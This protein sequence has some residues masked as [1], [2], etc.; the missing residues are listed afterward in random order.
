MKKF[1]C[2]IA[3]LSAVLTLSSCAAEKAQIPGKEESPAA[4]TE[5]APAETQSEIPEL[6]DEADDTKEHE[7]KLPVFRDP[8][9]ENNVMIYD[10]CVTDFGTEPSDTPDCADSTDAF[11]K[12]LDAAKKAGGGTVYVPAGYYRVDGKLIVPRSVCLAGEWYDPDTAP[13]KIADGTVIVTS[14]G[15]DNENS[16]FV[17]VG[18]SASVMGLTF[19]YPDQT[20][21]A[22][23]PC[24]ATVLLKDSIA[25]DGTQ[26][27]A[28]A[29]CLTFVNSYTAIDASRGNQLHYISSARITAFKMGFA[30]NECYDCGRVMSMSIR[31]D[32][33]GAFITALQG[34]SEGKNARDLAAE[35]MRTGATGVLL[36]R[37]D[38]QMMYDISISSCKTA[39]SLLRNPN[40]TG[41]T[42]GNGSII[43]F[44]IENC[45]TGIVCA[46]GSYKFSLGEI[47]TVGQSVTLCDTAVAS[48]DFYDCTLS[49]QHAETV[50]A[51][52]KSRG[53]LSFQNC[54]FSGW[55]GNAVSV[56][57]GSFESG[58]CTYTGEGI[59]IHINPTALTAVVDGSVWGENIT[60]PV[61][62]L[63]DGEKRTY[64]SDSAP[65]EKTEFILDFGKAPVPVTDNIVYVTDFGA[66]GKAVCG[67]DNNPD[68]TPAFEAAINALGGGGIVYVPA[69][70]YNVEGTLTVPAG[71]EIRGI[72]SGYHVTTGEGSVIFVTNGKGEADG[73]PFITLEKGSGVR[74]LTFWYPEQ[75][76]K[77]IEKYPFLIR[78]NGQDTWVR[79]IC[80]G[81]C[82]QAIDMGSADCGGHYI[83]NIT[84]CVLKKAIV[85]DGSTKASYL[86]NTHFN[87]SFYTAVWGTKLTDASGSFGQNDMF[88]TLLGALNGSLDAYTFGKTTDENVLFIFNYRA[89]TG[90]TFTGGFDGTV[91]GC[92]VDGSVA[93][94][95]ITGTYEKPLRLLNFADDIVPGTNEVGNT[96]IYSAPDEGSEVHFVASGASSYNY[97]PPYLVRAVSGKLV[98]RGFS[99]NVSPVGRSAAILVEGADVEA[100]GI[101]F[102]H[103]GPLDA[104]GAFTK[105]LERHRA[106]D[107]R[108]KS[109]RL[110]LNG[111]TASGFFSCDIDDSGECTALGYT[112]TEQ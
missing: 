55:A 22:I 12:A 25:G 8:R 87:L 48:F 83:E 94:V 49:S 67:V 105:Q 54:T 106:Y 100:S 52:E 3:F 20:P 5:S 59:G 75:N 102:R 92:G 29:S 84:G 101:T 69:G 78:G 108:V 9:D 93:G 45:E 51:Q 15:F 4:I 33:Y 30:V 41:E 111:A 60:S 2:L 32:Y 81:N 73:T 21:D 24:G 99:A 64:I 17:T 61:V 10:F 37:S 77:R 28:N 112:V 47:S 46:Y 35:A 104:K 34:E 109:G 36:M 57:G 18:A 89:A 43:D 23:K 63:L 44:T 70:Y 26:H 80:V 40:S 98:L 13:G 76:Y 42:A 74:G 71:V 62:N 1:L 79:D 50:L 19:Y 86:L 53:H 14:Y 11:K 58:S 68:D 88:S 31:P 6:T 97:V 107:V 72:H 39:F 38:W 66:D 110:R 16:A 85:V 95:K 103:V 7:M 65:L 56:L 82:Y 27:A 91:C 90:M 96:A